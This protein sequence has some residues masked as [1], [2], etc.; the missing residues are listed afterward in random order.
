VAFWTRIVRSRLQKSVAPLIGGTA[1]VRS[2]C[3][4][5][6]QVLLDGYMWEARCAGG[7]ERGDTVTVVSRDLLWLVVE[8]LDAGEQKGNAP[9]VERRRRRSVPSSQPA[10]FRP[11]AQV[12]QLG[13]SAVTRS[14]AGAAF[15]PAL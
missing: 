3:R 9:G 14:E 12:P 2:A 13:A 4:P 7:A 11:R 1:T 15:G 8:R 10:L 6:G 5:H